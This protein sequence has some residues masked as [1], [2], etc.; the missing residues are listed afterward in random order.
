MFVILV[1]CPGSGKGTQS[2]FLAQKFGF[3]HLSTGEMFRQMIE[4]QEP[5]GVLLNDYISHGKLVPSDLVNDIVYQFLSVEKYQNNCL[6]DG[7]PRNLSQA[8]FLS[9]KLPGLNINVIFFKID[10]NIAIKR[11]SGRFSCGSCGKIY[12]KYYYKPTVDNVCDVC[13]QQKFIYRADDNEAVVSARINEYFA[14]TYPLIDYYSKRNK[15][16]TIDA[17]Q[18]QDIISSNITDIILK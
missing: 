1:G 14:E 2:K 17:N 3:I 5:H 18:E 11:I 8:E 4:N 15:L 13:A 12:N 16:F 7:Y 9:N 10:E 6:L